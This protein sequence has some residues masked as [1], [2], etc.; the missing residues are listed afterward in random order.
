MRLWWRGIP[1][2]QAISQALFFASKTKARKKIDAKMLRRSAW[3]VTRDGAE[4]QYD[5]DEMQNNTM[6]YDV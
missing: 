2:P 4:L 6:L 5:D 3:R 1:G